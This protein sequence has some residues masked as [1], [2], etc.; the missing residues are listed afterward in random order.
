MDPNI[1]YLKIK[2]RREIVEKFDKRYRSMKIDLIFERFNDQ[3]QEIGI[4]EKGPALFEFLESIGYF[5]I[6]GDR[7]HY[8]Q[9][10][11]DQDMFVGSL[12]Q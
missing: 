7:V 8:L 9:D 12:Y 5:F 11:W 3:F 6:Y 4:E 1:E 10:D 2:L